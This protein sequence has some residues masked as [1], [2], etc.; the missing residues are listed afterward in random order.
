MPNAKAKLA[1]VSFVGLDIKYLSYPDIF[2]SRFVLCQKYESYMKQ[3][4]QQPLLGRKFR[5]LRR[6]V[7]AR[8]CY[9]RNA[10]RKRERGEEEGRGNMHV[11]ALTGK[12]TVDALS[13]IAKEALPCSPASNREEFERSEVRRRARGPEG[14]RA[15]ETRT[16]SEV[17]S[18]KAEDRL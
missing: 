13:L 15:V 17:G 1:T 6:V 11:N 2:Y 18:G 3:C 10:G 5:D 7:K 4:R 14:S 9:S 8:T 16:K 12:T